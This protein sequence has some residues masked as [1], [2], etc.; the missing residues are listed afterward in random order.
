MEGPFARTAD[1]KVS[2]S[3]PAVPE[4]AQTQTPQDI[5]RS[6]KEAKERPEQAA[7]VWIAKG[8]DRLSEEDKQKIKDAFAS[9]DENL[10]R[11]MISRLMQ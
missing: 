10:I 6:V 3:S 7:Q 4:A 2:E 1:I 9:G 11:T 5:D 8:G